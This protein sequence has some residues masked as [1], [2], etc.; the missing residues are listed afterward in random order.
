[1]TDFVVQMEQTLRTTSPAGRRAM[2]RGLMP[3]V[4]RW[5]EES[6]EPGDRPGSADVTLMLWADQVSAGLI[7]PLCAA[8]QRARSSVAA[9]ERVRQVERWRRR[10][11]GADLTEAEARP[12]ADG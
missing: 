11:G 5:F 1:M 6:L 2:L 10:R 9:V 3:V 4:A 12:A 8:T 7:G